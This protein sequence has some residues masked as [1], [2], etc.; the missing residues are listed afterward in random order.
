MTFILYGNARH[1]DGLVHHTGMATA[2]VIA[3]AEHGTLIV[4]WITNP[5]SVFLARCVRIPVSAKPIY[6][7]VG[8]A[9]HPITQLLMVVIVIAAH[10]IQIVIGML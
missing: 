5:G 6:P 4:I 8:G 10:G 9:L 3:N 7:Q 1:L 2:N